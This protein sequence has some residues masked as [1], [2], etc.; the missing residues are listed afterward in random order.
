MKQGLPSELTSLAM[1]GVLTSMTRG[2]NMARLHYKGKEKHPHL[3]CHTNTTSI[4]QHLPSST[5]VGIDATLISYTD[6]SS[7]SDALSAKDSSLVETK[8]NLVDH[9]WGSDRPKRPHEQVYELDVKYT[10]TFA[11]YVLRKHRVPNDHPG[12]STKDKLDKLR[13]QLVKREKKGIVITMLDEIA[14]L[15]NLRGS[16][17]D[18]NPGGHA[19]R[20]FVDSSTDGMV[21]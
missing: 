13:A 17:I 14:W 3:L 6:A 21:L 8:T 7:I 2:S 19:S 15:F 12:R 20:P 11:H 1:R 5:Q 18:Y 10:G 16:D 9:V 4:L